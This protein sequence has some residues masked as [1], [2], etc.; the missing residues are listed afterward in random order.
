MNIFAKLI[1]AGAT[2]ALVAAPSAALAGGNG[3]DLGIGQTQVNAAQNTQ[4]NSGSVNL[5][6][7]GGTNSNY[8]INQQATSVY[9]FGPGINCPTPEL[10]MGIFGGGA[11]ANYDG[12]YDSST[13]NYGATL[14]FSMPLG[15]DIGNSCKELAREI[16]TQRQLDTKLTMIKQC[17]A[18]AKAGIKVDT[19]D[20]KEFE[21]CRSV[22]IQG[23]TAVNVAEARQLDEVFAAPST[24]F[25]PEENVPVVIPVTP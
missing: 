25:T 15:G 6:P 24:P 14:M 11:G 4:T 13:N 16:A 21:A 2:L 10:A 19:K 7:I 9:G 3:Y 17:A 22:S 8:Q 1:T 23:V 5:A 20:F 12:G 18:I